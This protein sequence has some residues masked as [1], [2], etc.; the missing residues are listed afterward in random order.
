MVLAIPQIYV[1]SEFPDPAA[2]MKNRGDVQ[3]YGTHQ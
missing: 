3:R 2:Q 1:S